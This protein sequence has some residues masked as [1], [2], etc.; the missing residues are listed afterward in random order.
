M[1]AVLR[2]PK[3]MAVWGFTVATFLLILAWKTAG[4]YGVDRFLLHHLGVPWEKPI[5]P[6]P[7]SSSHE[8]IPTPA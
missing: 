5:A 4:Y 1:R 6:A 2:N 8:Q 3:V 7:V